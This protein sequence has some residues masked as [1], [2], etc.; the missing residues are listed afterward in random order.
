M[1]T[2][3]PFWIL[4]SKTACLLITVLTLLGRTKIIHAAPFSIQ[5]PGVHASD[6]R[7]TTFAA[8]LDYPLGMAQ[9]SDGSL[10]IAVSEGMSFWTST[11]KLIR[12]VDADRDGIADGPGTV[13]FPG[14]PGGQTSLRIGGNLIFVTGQGQGK[15]ISILRAGAAPGDPL[16]LVGK[17]IISYPSGSWLHPHSALGIRATPGLPGSY[18]LFFQLGSDRNFATTTQTAT[19]TNENIAGVSG[20]LKGDS[21]YML[22]VTD[23]TTSVTASNP[24]R[25]ASGLRNPAGFAFHQVTGD[26]YFEDNGIDGFVDPNEPTSA[27]ELNRIP[28]AEIGGTTVEDFGFPTNYTAYRSGTVVGGA[29]V[30]PLVAFQPLPD[31]MT[32]SESEGPNDIAFAPSSFPDG[33][34]NG[35]FVGFHGKFNLGGRTNE[36]NPLVYVDLATFTYF[37]FIGND[38]P[39]VGHLDGLLATE[40]SLFVADLASNGNLSNGGGFG[41]IYQIKSLARPS[42]SYRRINNTLELTW[43]RGVLQEADGVSE[44]WKDLLTAASPYSIELDQPRK[45]YRAKN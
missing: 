4:R 29:G 11:G 9:L 18:D 14:L 45:F 22:T 7:I 30:Q 28:A 6:F 20:T 17:I 1:T 31:P 41:M 16:T 35:I 39:N 5:G 24:T 12:L 26:L 21:I 19:I 23:H 34:N 33:L 44:T 25:I 8:G 2:F 37:H 27:D 42:L 43:T 38:E 32:G 36:E 40:D 3:C 13:L 15:P 10:L